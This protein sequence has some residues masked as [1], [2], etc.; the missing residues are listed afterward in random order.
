MDKEGENLR[1]IFD[2]RH[3]PLERADDQEEED[4]LAEEDVR[5][6]HQVR[7]EA[8]HRVDHQ[9]E[10]ITIETGTISKEIMKAAI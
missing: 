3:E 7:Q 4:P 9:E 1:M 10:T 5:E 6:D 8:D 2:L